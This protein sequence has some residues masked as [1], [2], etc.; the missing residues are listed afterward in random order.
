MNSHS[1]D[2]PL[3]FLHLFIIFILLK[4]VQHHISY[5]AYFAE[6]LIG[7][8]VTMVS[9]LGSCRVFIRSWDLGTHT[10]LL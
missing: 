3:K 7:S 6:K 8:G 10:S 1:V 4:K 9:I 2:V 5:Q